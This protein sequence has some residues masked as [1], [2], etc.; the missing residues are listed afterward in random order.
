MKKRTQILIW[1][2]PDITT[3]EFKLNAEIVIFKTWND[4]LFIGYYNCLTNNFYTNSDVDDHENGDV[5][6]L[7]NDIKEFAIIKKATE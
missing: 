6:Y 3:M 2:S 4:Q 1:E 7:F 5:F